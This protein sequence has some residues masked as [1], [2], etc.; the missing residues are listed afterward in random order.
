MIFFSYSRVFTVAPSLDNFTILKMFSCLGFFH[1]YWYVFLKIRIVVFKIQIRYYGV[2]NLSRIYNRTREQRLGI[3]G[4]TRVE[5]NP[6][7]MYTFIF[8]RQT[9]KK[10]YMLP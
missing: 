2:V 10:I 5:T 8:I 6:P 9:F 4:G 7:K 3:G 1:F